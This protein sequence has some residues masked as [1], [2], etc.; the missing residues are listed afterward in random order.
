VGENVWFRF[1]VTNDGNVLLSNLS[2]DDSNH[3]VSGCGVSGRLASGGSAT[4]TIGP[5]AALEGQHV[6]TA[7]ASGDYGGKTY[8]DED[9]AHYF[10]ANPSIDIEKSIGLGNGTW[11]DADR[12]P[13][14]SVLEGTNVWFQFVVTNDG[15]VPLRNVVLSD[16]EYDVS[17][18][19]VPTRLAPGRSST[20]VIGPFTPL[21]GEYINT[22]T[23][24]GDYSGM[25]Y[26]DQDIVIFSVITP[27][28]QT[29]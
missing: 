7:T 9:K 10:G 28:A 27:T 21:P 15:N 13:G 5:F 20:C 3:D 18:C 22:G 12:R 8:E 2:L 1:V 19:D 6:D 23:V 14:P 29:E 25:T 4:C 16:S 24:A 11:H 26:T 17:G